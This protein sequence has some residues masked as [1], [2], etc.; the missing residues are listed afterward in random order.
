MKNLSVALAA[1]VLFGA[2]TLLPPVQSTASPAVPAP[3]AAPD[4]YTVDNVH[5]S[6]TFRIKHMGIAYIYGRFNEIAGNFR[7]DPADP[8]EFSIDVQLKA[9]SIDTKA[10]GRD[11]HLKGPDFFNA[12][13]YPSISFKSKKATKDGAN[14]YKVSG[15]LQLHGVTRPVDVKIEHTGS[16]NFRGYREGF[17]AK[18]TIKRSDF[19][20]K[21]MLR[22]LGDE[23]QL[24]VSVEGVRK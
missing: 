10:P 12:K 5:S 8:S 19:G 9:E 1:V 14:R 15:D 7:Y 3:A 13:E 20:M 6:V 24:T 22:G 17:E 11:R 2:I 16:G 21:Y 23:V 4:S 18:F